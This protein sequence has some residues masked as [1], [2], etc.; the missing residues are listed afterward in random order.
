MNELVGQGVGAIIGTGMDI[1]S[2]NRAQA[3]YRRNQEAQNQHEASMMARQYDLNM[4]YWNETTTPLIYTERSEGIGAAF[5][6]RTDR[7]E[8]ATEAKDKIH[9]SA[10]ARR[11]NKA[12][13]KVIKNDGLSAETEST[14]G[15]G[16]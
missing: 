7:W 12:D 5:N 6:I 13:M 15:T 11:E 2:E 1:M 9:R 14:Q 3:R 16:N 10:I 8:I 4:K